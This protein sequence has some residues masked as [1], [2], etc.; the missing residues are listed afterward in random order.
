[1]ERQIAIAARLRGGIPFEVGVAGERAQ[2]ALF[3]HQSEW[4]PAEIG[5]YQHT[6]AVHHPAGAGAPEGF[7]LAHTCG[8]HVR[9]DAFGSSTGGPVTKPPSMLVDDLPNEACAVLVGEPHAR[10]PESGVL[11]HFVD[12]GKRRELGL[13]WPPGLRWSP[14]TRARR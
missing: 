1:L 8:Y 4:R 2:V 13:H 10:L 11:E 9:K 5:V 7:R 3:N 14:D 6:R 12:R